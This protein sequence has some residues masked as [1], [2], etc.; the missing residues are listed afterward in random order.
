M[1]ATVGKSKGVCCEKKGARCV[2]VLCAAYACALNVSFSKLAMPSGR[3]VTHVWGARPCRYSCLGKVRCAL[4]HSRL[5]NTS[6]YGIHL[7]L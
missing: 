7:P 1:C 4:G 3:R 5:Q 2:D 6:T